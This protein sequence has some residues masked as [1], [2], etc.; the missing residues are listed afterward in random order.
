MREVWLV[1][2]CRNSPGKVY[3]IFDNRKA[4]DDFA[5]AVTDM[6]TEVKVVNRSV[7]NGQP[8]RCGWNQ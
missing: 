3:A 7:Y 5:E 1:E 2:D 4:A 6:T 8:P